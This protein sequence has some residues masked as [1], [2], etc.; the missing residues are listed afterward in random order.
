MPH[1]LELNDF[2]RELLLGLLE[3]ERAELCSE[4]HHARLANVREELRQRRA[5]VEALR[6][7]LQ[8]TCEPAE[9]EA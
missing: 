5:Q 8:A 2:E 1:R 3:R 6:H 9:S 7:R 4:I